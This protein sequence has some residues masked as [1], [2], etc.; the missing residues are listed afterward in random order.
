MGHSGGGAIVANLIGRHPED[1]DA[2][3][4]LSCGCDPNEFMTR[5][6]LQH[7]R[8]QMIRPN[9]SLLPLDLAPK[10]PRR[11]HVR[12]LIGDK[13]DVVLLPASQAYFNALKSRGVDATFTV[14]PGFG[15]NDIFRAVQVRDALVEALT[16]EGAT[17]RPPERSLV[18]AVK[19]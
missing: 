6:V 3:V 5:W 7:P 8:F 18:T 9:P 13:D 10:V 11:M 19:F 17:V 15:H 1:V 4:I 12:M 16:L 2:A 14:A